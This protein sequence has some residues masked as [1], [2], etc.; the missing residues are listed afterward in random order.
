MNNETKIENLLHKIMIGGSVHAQ[1]VTCGKSNCKC[2]AGKLHGP[3]YYFFTRI[4]GKL[5][6]Q[7]L[8]PHEVEQTVRDCL[9]QRRLRNL[10]REEIRQT[11][12]QLRRIRQHLQSFNEQYTSE[13]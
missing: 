1:Y 7:Y 12:D 4:E 3:Y 2:A 9:E 11:W 8:K 13:D 5:K 6:K 10:A